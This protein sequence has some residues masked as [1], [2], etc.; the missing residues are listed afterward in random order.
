MRN[1]VNAFIRDGAVLLTRRSPHR[2]VY[3]GLWSFPGGH[4]E[5]PHETLVE[6]LVREVREEVGVV[7]I[8]FSFLVSIADPNASDVDPTT[9]HMYSVTAWKG[10]EPTLLGDEHTELQWFPL[11]TAIAL[12]D[13]ALDE[14]RGSIWRYDRRVK[15]APIR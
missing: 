13:L 2:S 14:Y 3:P 12:P 8:S 1:I 10:G 7:P 6:A 11:A 15:P 9:Y 5:E 4:V